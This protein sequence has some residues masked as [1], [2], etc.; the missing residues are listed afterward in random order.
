M[1]HTLKE[2]DLHQFT[3]SEYW[4]NC[5]V[6]LARPRIYAVSLLHKEEIGRAWKTVSLILNGRILSPE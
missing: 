4:Q 1:T 3:G 6:L 5:L 2:A